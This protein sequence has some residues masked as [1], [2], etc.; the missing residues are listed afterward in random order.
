MPPDSIGTS[1]Q[2]PPMPFPDA[3]RRL[4]VDQVSRVFAVYPSLAG[5]ITDAA[6]AMHIVDRDEP[7][8]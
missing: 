1:V 4:T 7:E 2:H 3:T 8:E 5:T 6:R